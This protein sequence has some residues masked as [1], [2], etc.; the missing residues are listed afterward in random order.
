[1]KKRIFVA[2]ASVLATFAAIIASSACIWGL[3]QPEEPEQ[4]R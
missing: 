3:Y 2:I 1:M 4:L